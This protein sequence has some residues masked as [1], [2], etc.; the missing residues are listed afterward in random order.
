MGGLGLF[1]GQKITSSPR[2]IDIGVFTV[3]G[4]E[5]GKESMMS[6]LRETSK[7]DMS[8]EMTRQTVST[9]RSLKEE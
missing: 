2:L 7:T 4:G 5:Q 9:E 6:S 3:N 1:K 8:K